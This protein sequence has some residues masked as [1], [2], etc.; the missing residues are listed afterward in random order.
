[1]SA[2]HRNVSA[3]APCPIC[4]APDLCWISAEGDVVGCRREPGASNQHTDRSGVPFWIYSQDASG[5]W[6]PGLAR[7]RIHT[8]PD[9]AVLED[10]EPAGARRTYSHDRAAPEDLDAAYRTLIAALKLDVG[11]E[12]ALMGERGFVRSELER[13]GY[14]SRIGPFSE[15]AIQAVRHSIATRLY[16]DWKARLDEQQGLHEALADGAV[17]QPHWESIFGP[18]WDAA[19]D[20][21]LY[22]IPGLWRDAGDRSGRAR[23]V[24]LAQL[25]RAKTPRD[26]SNKRRH[27]ARISGERALLAA[28]VEGAEFGPMST[29]CA[30][31]Q[32]R[33]RSRL[34]G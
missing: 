25:Q 11:H 18:G 15:D 13:A 9:E 34:E 3:Q 16:P 28:F 17:F 4:Q 33:R 32:S 2:S 14:R 24:R 22:R 1:M 8:Q 27:R 26:H 23:R 10:T 29:R 6:V 30:P 5:T 31:F 12:Q 20:R 7:G 21:E 19:V